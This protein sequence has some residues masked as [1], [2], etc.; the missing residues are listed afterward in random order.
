MGS[1]DNEINKEV[2]SVI[3]DMSIS[4]FQPA[5]ET[6]DE[7][8]EDLDWDPAS[9]I[10]EID[11]ELYTQKEADAI[12]DALIKTKHIYTYLANVNVR[13]HAPW[14]DEDADITVVAIIKGYRM[15]MGRGWLVY[16]LDF[17]LWDRNDWHAPKAK[18]VVA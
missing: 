8:I 18:E 13:R 15:E 1:L 4:G 11:A 10:M 7:P 2:E 17:E 3:A 5:S 6:W 16:Y 12:L 14:T 9:C